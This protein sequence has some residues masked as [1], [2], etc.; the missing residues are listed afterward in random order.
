MVAFKVFE[1]FKT[2]FKSHLSIFFSILS[3]LVSLVNGRYCKSIK[4]KLQAT[5]CQI[6]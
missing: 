2:I 4:D 5:P 1:Y 6:I 3:N